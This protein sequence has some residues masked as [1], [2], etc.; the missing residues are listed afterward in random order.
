MEVEKKTLKGSEQGDGAAPGWGSRMIHEAVA[1]TLVSTARAQ[2]K[3]RCVTSIK[4]EEGMLSKHSPRAYRTNC[5]GRLEE[6]MA[7][8]SC[9][10]L[11]LLFGGDSVN[12]PGL[13]ACGGCRGG[14]GGLLSTRKLLAV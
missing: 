1:H 6:R 2:N 4:R 5:L 8:K 12:R 13:A 10:D 9:G 11:S 14:T 7:F 3:L